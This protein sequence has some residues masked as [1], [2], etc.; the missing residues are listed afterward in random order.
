MCVGCRATADQ[1]DLVRIARTASGYGLSR[2]AP[3]RGAWLHPGCGALALKRRAIPRA[4]KS[5]A[6]DPARLAA[7]VAEVDSLAPLGQ[8]GGPPTR[9][10]DAIRADRA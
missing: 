9:L 8:I 10:A 3:G 7:V 4:L 6:G 1:A 2:T 5:D